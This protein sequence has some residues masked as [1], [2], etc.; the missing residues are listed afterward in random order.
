LLRNKT[1]IAGNLLTLPAVEAWQADVG[2]DMD[3][4]SA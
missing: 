2:K 4:L 3:T 1:G